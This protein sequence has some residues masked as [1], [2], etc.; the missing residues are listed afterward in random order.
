MNYKNLRIGQ[1]LGLAFI[2][3]LTITI[4][5]AATSYQRITLLEQADE[6]MAR[7]TMEQ[8]R[9]M[10]EWTANI[11][12]NLV[13]TNAVIVATDQAYVEKT[14]AEMDETSVEIKKFENLIHPLLR[15]SH[16]E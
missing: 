12:L 16:R 3:I 1:R 4:A 5:L 11:R 15:S 14:L 13:R 9:L 8:Q 6:N 2:V 10:S 7:V